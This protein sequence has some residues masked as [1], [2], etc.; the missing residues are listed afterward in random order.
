MERPEDRG[1]YGVQGSGRFDVEEAGKTGVLAAIRTDQSKKRGCTMNEE[2]PGFAEARE[3][4]RKDGRPSEW[5]DQTVDP[6]SPYALFEKDGKP[7]YKCN[8]PEYEGFWLDGGIGSVQC[9]AHDGLLPGLHFELTCR[10]DFEMC[11][12][13]RRK[14][15]EP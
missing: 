8:C 9:R 10:K 4:L 3:R 7:N 14:E 13:K 15:V 11:P 12:F 6:Q 1:C 5:I 2:L